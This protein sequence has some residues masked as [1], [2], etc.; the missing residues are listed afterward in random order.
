MGFLIMLV[1]QQS[2]IVK[3]SIASAI[4]QRTRGEGGMASNGR[5]ANKGHRKGSLVSC[6]EAGRRINEEKKGRAKVQKNRKR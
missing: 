3:R 4:I 1:I 5:V 6:G 2:I